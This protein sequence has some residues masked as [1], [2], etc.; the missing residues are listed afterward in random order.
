MWVYD[1]KSLVFLAVNLAAVE[2]Y[3]YS[4]NEFLR[5]TIRDIRP[6]QDI[7]TLL[8]IVGQQVEGLLTSSECKHQKKD[9]SLIDVEI[10]SH[11]LDWFGRSA[12]LVL[13]TDITERTRTEERLIRSEESYRKLVEESPD[14][15]LVHRHGTII[16]ANSACARLFGAFSV[17]ELLGRQHLDSVHPNDRE[18]VKERIH[19]FTYDLESVRWYE[20]RFLHLDGTDIYAEVV[21]RSVVFN[22][23]PSIQVV[24]RDISERLQAEKT[25][26]RREADLA[27]AQRIAHLG[28]YEMDLSSLDGFEKNPLQWS[29]ENF[30]IFGYEPG[31]IG[32]SGAT[33]LAALHPEDKVRVREELTRG[34]RE[35]DSISLEYRIIRPSGAVR[36]IHSHTNVIRDEKT[37]RLV[38]LVGTAQ[39]ITERK[40]AEERFYKAFNA[41]PEPMTIATMSN[42][43][44]MDVN[45]SFLRI[46]G[47]RREEVIGHTSLDLQF[48]ERPEDRGKFIE[49]LTKR[50]SVRDLEII[51]HTKSGEQ[52]TGMILA[53]IIEIDGQTCV[54]AIVKDFTDQ[55]AL[56][57]Q[58]R[59]AQKMEAIGQLSGG[60]A[61]DF[62]NLLG[63]I[64][65]YSEVL[66]EGLAAGDSLHKG[67]QEIKK[68]GERAASLTRQLLA[69]SRQQV[70]DSRILDL[71]TVI[72]SVEKMLGRLIGE[73]IDLESALEPD[74][75]NIKA[76]QG[77]IEQ[78]VINLA[79]N[80]RDAMPHGGRLTIL[81]AN[82]DLDED[83]ALSHS[84]QLPGRYVLLSV[85]DTGIGM[86]ATTQAHI[87]DPF[88][89]TKEQ[90]KGTG[91]G[92]ST[93]YGV[94][95]QS[96]GHIW[97]YSEPGLGT[98]FKIYLPRTDE[99]VHREKP[100]I[101]LATSLRGTETILLVED[102]EALR[103]L[104]RSLLAN[105]GYTVLSAEQPA[106]AIEIAGQH[107]GPIHLLLTDVV[108]PGMSGLAL[109][110]KLAPSRPDMRVLYMSGY[111]GFTHPELLDSN[112]D[113][114]VK[115]VARD[116]LFRKVHEVLALDVRSRSI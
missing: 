30:R 31:Q 66:E 55:K 87:F 62:N 77:Q 81:T 49:I 13:A 22:G 57:K 69:F 95:R 97:V 43:L 114:L 86:D 112:A 46:T 71:N 72:G 48:W 20:T 50:G 73:N 64:I 44:Y 25:L 65:G 115:P 116:T 8:D 61:H 26:R 11:D 37:N 12:R 106:D 6:A 90:G 88:F 5:M 24:L 21:A 100:A 17:N 102:E 60:I 4:G 2:Q 67:V 105:C 39:D 113:I 53:E 35:G 82:V 92:L 42:G 47:Y 3:G 91:L 101:G 75:G 68:A 94:I 28:S 52:R 1:V 15:M 79:V 54:L 98:T 59:Q 103:E 38:R 109:A 14:A 9:G 63:V 58:L 27:V 96:G 104:T 76:D 7:P 93:V 85:S 51:F 23:E 107:K 34:I 83:Y 41:N 19:K 16:F 36:F 78:V 108:M 110:G 33:F 18:A 56:E 74:L 89:T 40:K 70:L 99:A 32:V 45:E 84:P 111:T 80:A 29:D 10:T